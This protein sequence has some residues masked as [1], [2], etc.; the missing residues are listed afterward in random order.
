MEGSQYCLGHL[1][2]IYVPKSCQQWRTHHSMEAL[3]SRVRIPGR[4][5]FVG[6]T[7][8]WPRSLCSIDLGNG[9][10]ET[11]R[12]PLSQRCSI[13][14]CP[15]RWVELLAHGPLNGTRPFYVV[16]VCVLHDAMASWAWH[17]VTRLWMAPIDRNLKLQSPL[18]PTPMLINPTLH[19]LIQLLWRSQAEQQP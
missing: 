14:E 7:F 3:P 2:W 13:L 17:G 10:C 12:Q 16:F 19:V 15:G 6:I 8:L 1:F 11:D 18:S 4:A 5:S 9:G